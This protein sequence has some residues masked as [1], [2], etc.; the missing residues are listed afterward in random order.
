MLLSSFVIH[1]AKEVK[2]FENEERKAL[3]FFYFFNFH[4]LI[5]FQ[6]QNY[7]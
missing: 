3:F 5:N 6:K 7:V 4:E 2:N 1:Y